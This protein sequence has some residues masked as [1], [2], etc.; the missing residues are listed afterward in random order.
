MLRAPVK[1]PMWPIRVRTRYRSHLQLVLS[2]QVE[3]SVAP[4]QPLTVR[5][6]SAWSRSTCVCEKC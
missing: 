3:A 5:W 2:E 4:S 6:P 1:V